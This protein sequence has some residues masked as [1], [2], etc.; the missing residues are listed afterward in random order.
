MASITLIVDGIILRDDS[1][2]IPELLRRGREM[3]L[4]LGSLHKTVNDNLTKVSTLMADVN[5]VIMDAFASVKTAVDQYVADVTTLIAQQPEP[6]NVQPFLDAA[7]A[8]QTAVG[9]ADAAVKQVLTP[10]TPPVVSGMQHHH[11]P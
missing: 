9:D 1:N 8:L 6:V 10:V 4:T 11:N 7:S 5:Q 3:Q 2:L